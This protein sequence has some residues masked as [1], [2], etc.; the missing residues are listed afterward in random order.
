M[1]FGDLGLEKDGL[2]SGL[3]TEVLKIMV[4]GLVWR[5]KS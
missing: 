3:E 4:M 1:G 5:L 2:G